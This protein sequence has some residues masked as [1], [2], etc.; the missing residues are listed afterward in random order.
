MFVVAALSVFWAVSASAASAFVWQ[1]EEKPLANGASEAIKVEKTSEKLIVETSVLGVAIKK[2]SNAL[3]GIETKITQ[4]GAVASGS[5][6]L[7]FSG[8]VF[9]EPAACKVKE[10]TVTTKQTKGEVVEIGG[11]FYEKFT[12]A[13]GETFTTITVEGCAIAGTYKFTGSLFGQLEKAGVSLVCQPITF[14]K[15][16]QETAGGVLH[17][18][19]E[20]AFVI[21][22]AKFCLSGANAGKKFSFK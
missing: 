6:K 15:A 21:G 14:S 8:V 19:P 10:G 1:I 22:A 12:P 20:K 11:N 9:D 3:T 4:S 18:G 16:I 17:F 13:E 7:Q 2:T 5:G